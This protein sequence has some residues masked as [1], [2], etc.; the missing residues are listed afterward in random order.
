MSI[1][2]VNRWLTLAANIG[3]LIGIAFLIVEINQNT[4]AT[5]TAS[6]DASVEH[7]L[8][9]FEQGMDNQ[10]IARARHKLS[11]GEELDGFERQQL[12]SYQYYNFKIFL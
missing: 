10:V 2:T 12:Y 7:I 5:N 9:F 3:V 11:S 8:N 6:R 4:Q 1:D